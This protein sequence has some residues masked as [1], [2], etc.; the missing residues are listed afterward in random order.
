MNQMGL[1]SGPLVMS[2]VRLEAIKNTLQNNNL[3]IAVKLD[4]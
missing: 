4:L 1:K 2:G 3:F